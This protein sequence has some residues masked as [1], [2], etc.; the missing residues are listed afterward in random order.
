[1]YANN[2]LTVNNILNVCLLL[3]YRF[4]TS[5]PGVVYA[6][7][8]RDAEVIEFQLLKDAAV[9]PPAIGVPVQPPPG[10]DMARQEYLFSKLREFCADDAKDITCPKPVHSTHQPTAPKPIAP[11]PTPQRKNTWKKVGP[12][13]KSTAPKKRPARF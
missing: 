9:K 3:Y 1:M 6:Q 8:H 13:P 12:R 7:R 2:Y 11:K 5:K 4:D 10:L